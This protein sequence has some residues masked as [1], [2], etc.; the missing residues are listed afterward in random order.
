VSASSSRF[1]SERARVHAPRAGRGDPG[2]RA[3]GRSGQRELPAWAR[4]PYACLTLHI[5]LEHTT[6]G[7]ILAGDAF[8]R[9]I[10]IALR[11][12]GSYH[13][14]YNRH[15]LRTQIDTCFPHFQQF[16]RLKKKYD[17]E[18]LFQSDWYRGYRRMYF[19]T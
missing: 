15:G 17:P 19:G 6:R 14:A 11:H 10:D 16:L 12:G 7:S 13:L 3:P 5:H 2:E 1:S 4:K 18:E 8:R 9:L